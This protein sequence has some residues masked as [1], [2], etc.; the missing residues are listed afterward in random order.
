MLSSFLANFHR[1]VFPE[2]VGK[3]KKQVPASK[4]LHTCPTLNCSVMISVDV[5]AQ[6]N[7]CPF[8]GSR[9]NAQYYTDSLMMQGPQTLPPA[10]TLAI[11]QPRPQLSR[12]K[13]LICDVG[14]GLEDQIQ[15]Y[16]PPTSE[17]YLCFLARGRKRRTNP[18]YRLFC[19]LGQFFVGFSF[20]SI[21]YVV[22]CVLGL[23]VSTSAINC[24]E[25][26]VSK[27]T[28]YVWCGI[29]NPTCSPN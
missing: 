17:P 6:Q 14:E 12:L 15:F 21:V 19:Y 7:K 16:V 27:M 24:L 22:F 5:D 1:N 18:Q 10:N 2:N 28:Y 25:R 20:V 26:F 23:V 4:L 9:V 11:K 8:Q 3:S 29:L 13:N